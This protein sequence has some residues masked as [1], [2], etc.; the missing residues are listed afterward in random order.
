MKPNKRVAKNSPATKAAV[1]AK[2]FKPS[3]LRDVADR[4][5]TLSTS[6]VPSRRTIDIR[7]IPKIIRNWDKRVGCMVIG[8]KKG[9]AA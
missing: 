7:G 1:N 5:L 9:G 4:F 8:S 2:I 3:L 6:K